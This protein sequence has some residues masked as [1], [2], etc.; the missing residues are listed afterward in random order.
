MIFPR[1]ILR[2]VL[3]LFRVAVV[4]GYEDPKLNKSGNEAQNFPRA[5][6]MK[7]SDDSTLILQ[8]AILVKN[9]LDFL[10]NQKRLVSEVDKDEKDYIHRHYINPIYTALSGHLVGILLNSALAAEWSEET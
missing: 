6:L 10:L 4:G 1:E 7:F 2:E 5:Y 9:V 3:K 8:A